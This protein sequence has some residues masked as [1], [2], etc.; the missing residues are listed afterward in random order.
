MNNKDFLICLLLS[1]F[2][3]FAVKF[4]WKWASGGFN[5]GAVWEW[6]NRG[7]SFGLG[8][9]ASL[10]LVILIFKLVVGG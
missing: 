10:I 5:N 6:M 9:F 1:V 2:V 3:L 7:F 4:F 8:F